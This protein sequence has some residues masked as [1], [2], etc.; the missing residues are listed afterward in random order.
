MTD[1]NVALFLGKDATK[2]FRVE[3][4]YTAAAGKVTNLAVK[5]GVED[6]LQLFA[7]LI[8]SVDT[9][10]VELA[11]RLISPKKGFLGGPAEDEGL[12]SA[13]IAKLTTLHSV[14]NYR[15]SLAE[16]KPNN[17]EISKPVG[18]AIT[19]LL[20]LGVSETAMY[21]INHSAYRIAP[22]PDASIN[23]L[24][25]MADLLDQL[26]SCT[27]A[28]LENLA[29]NSAS[30]PGEGKLG[31]KLFKSEV[32]NLFENISAEKT[33][34]DTATSLAKLQTSD[35]IFDIRNQIKLANR[36]RFLKNLSPLN[37]D[38]DPR[39]KELLARKARLTERIEGS[40]AGGGGG[41]SRAGGGGGSYRMGGG[42]Y[43]NRKTIRNRKTRRG[44][45]KTRKTNKSKSRKARKTHK[46]NRHQ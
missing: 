12:T 16:D 27:G 38:D 1:A 46:N 21:T 24:I 19:A 10:I 14:L 4:E 37:P 5:T 3:A 41:G 32:I 18:D 22:T 33:L 11:N 13:C 9:Y 17:I 39:I 25:S 8:K 28:R 30:K 43:K 45:Q 31:T 29:K 15:I 20:G 26:K 40:A 44:G 7:R 35:E 34:L 23:L 6:S 36:L 2:V 42:A